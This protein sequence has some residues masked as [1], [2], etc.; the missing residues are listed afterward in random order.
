MITQQVTRY[1]SKPKKDQHIEQHVKKA[2]MRKHMRKDDPGM[3][4]IPQQVLLKEKVL[5]KFVKEAAVIKATRNHECQLRKNDHEENSHI[6]NDQAGNRIT[7]LKLET[8]VVK[9]G[10]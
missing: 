7:C 3:L 8:D 10:S 2:N 6:D 9:N 5:Y 1:P 4:Y